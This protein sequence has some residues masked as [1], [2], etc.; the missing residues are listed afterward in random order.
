MEMREIVVPTYKPGV[1]SGREQG[2]VQVITDLVEKRIILF[3]SQGKG[4]DGIFKALMVHIFKNDVFIFVF[5][6][7]HAEKPCERNKDLPGLHAVVD[8]FLAGNVFE[9]PHVVEPV[10]KLDDGDPDVAGRGQKNAVVV[11]R[12][13]VQGNFVLK[14]GV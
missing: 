5:D 4:F 12:I 8:L 7:F 13:R 6:G 14:G 3:F 9:G 1:D 11:R 2:F 10:G